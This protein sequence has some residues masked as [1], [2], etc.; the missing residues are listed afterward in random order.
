VVSG[1]GI[2]GLMAVHDLNTALRYSDRFLFMKSGKILSYGGI[3]DVTADM[4][5]EVYG[6]KVILEDCK[7]HPVVIPV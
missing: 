5:E 7:G 3:E 1:H 6:V 2:T 4:I